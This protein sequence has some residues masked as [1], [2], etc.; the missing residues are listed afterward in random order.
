L[1]KKAVVLLSGGIDSTT[2]LALARA[3]GFEVYALTIDYGQRHRVELDAAT[4]VA[5]SLSAKEHKI[6]TVDLRAVGGSA[7]TS[8]MD[9]PKSQE[10]ETVLSTASTGFPTS[11]PSW[12][13]VR[14]PEGIP[15]TYVPAR[16]T[17]F[18]SLA[19]SW[20]E[21]IGATAVFIGATAVDYSGYPDCRPE[22]IEAFQRVADLGTKAGAEGRPIR[23]RAP[24]VNV[25]KS[26]I[27]R[28]GL[29]LGVDYSLTH[30]CYDPADDGKACGKC[31]SCHF[32]RKAFAEAGVK[33]PTVYLAAGGGASGRDAPFLRG[34]R[35]P[36]S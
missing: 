9:V 21:A 15:S 35:A 17:I 33:D 10:V 24:F 12:Y 8:D 22:Y 28:T 14:K 4:R 27:I 13:P 7:L 16:N 19:L 18:L 30:S 11:G 5:S 3:E 6:M 23:I 1:P 34:T 25:P 32:R 31:D 29:R 26:Q 2:T 36:D 20:A